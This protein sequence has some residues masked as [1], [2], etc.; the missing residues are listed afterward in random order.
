MSAL[1]SK[2]N[3]LISL[4]NLNPEDLLAIVKVRDLPVKAVLGSPELEQRNTL[5]VVV[6]DERT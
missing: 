6:T 1:P 2:S 3:M 5:S 4:K